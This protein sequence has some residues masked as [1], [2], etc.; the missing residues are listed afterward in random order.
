MN[1]VIY[2]RY[3]SHKQTEQ[4]VEGQLKDCYAY[5]QKHS[6]TVVGEYV[7]RAISG[8]TDN[9]PE[10]RRMIEDSKKKRFQ[11]VLVWK[12]D[13]FSRDRYDS[14]INKRKLKKNGVRVFSAMEDIRDDSSG[15]IL[16]SVLEGV[17]E[18]FSRDLA[19]KV[20]RGMLVSAEKCQYNGGIVPLGFKIENKQYK[21]DE[22]A[23]PI[24]K[25][26]FEM[27]AQGFTVTSI[28]EY[29]KSN[30]IYTNANREFNKTN[31]ITMLSNK[32]YIGTYTFCDI[33]IEGGIPRIVSDELFAKVQNKLDLA[34][35]KKEKS[36]GKLDY[37]LSTKLFC[38]HCK[39]MMIGYSGTSKTGKQYHYYICKN[40]KGAKRT[41]DKKNVRKEYIE[42]L[43]VDKCKEL[44]TDENIELICSEIE[45]LNKTESGASNIRYIERQIKDKKKAI[46]NLLTAIEKG[47]LSDIIT[48]RL[49]ALNDEVKELTERLEE[50]TALVNDSKLLNAKAV[51]FFF[52]QLRNGKADDI[53]YRK[54]LV[55]IFVNKVFVYDNKLVIFHNMGGKEIEITD[56]LLSE[57]ESIS[58]SGNKAKK[59]SFI[60]NVGVPKEISLG[61]S[62]VW[63]IFSFRPL[64]A[65]RKS[66]ST[67]S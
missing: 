6:Y 23:A 41:C 5:A 66:T 13:R 18:A 60:S 57:V 43:V 32:K 10:F 14:A 44:L 64:P 53:L 62:P 29:L 4:S 24:A 30:R 61:K 38:G 39:D 3:S 35:H 22:D 34:K 25:K 2:A 16:E 49:S 40:A 55:N 15:I 63:A 17:A 37:I 26:I 27:Y 31:L 7:D 42:D 52:Y 36:A 1:I 9:R 21:I 67:R 56:L 8:R 45:K 20:K 65:I 54:M 48:E 46:S 59:S 51:K 12:L 28:L 50:E 47:N 11:G 58:D 33:V 19:E